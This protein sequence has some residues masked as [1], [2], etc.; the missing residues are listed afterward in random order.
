MRISTIGNVEARLGIRLSRLESSRLRLGVLGCSVRHSGT[1]RVRGVGITCL[2]AYGVGTKAK[3]G[4]IQERPYSP[5]PVL[6]YSNGGD[7]STLQIGILL[8]I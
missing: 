3:C 1:I 2:I 4:V 5:T 7:D 6:P 8:Q